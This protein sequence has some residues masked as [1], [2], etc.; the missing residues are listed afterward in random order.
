M[1]WSRDPSNS[2]HTVRIKD[3]LD[4]A[5]EQSSHPERQRQ[6]WIVLAGLNRIYGLAG[7]PEPSRQIALRPTP[8]GPE[9][10]Q[11]IDHWYFRP[12]HTIPALQ[13]TNIATQRTGNAVV[14]D[15]SGTADTRIANP[16][17]HSDNRIMW[18]GWEAW[19][20]GSFP[21]VG[22]WMEGLGKSKAS[23]T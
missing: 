23:L 18:A 7:D 11:P 16:A 1:W 9:H 17:D 6:T 12:T 14:A 4:G 19:L 22:S 13:K 10:P 15:T 8:L 5:P 2:C 20:V 3:R 21:K